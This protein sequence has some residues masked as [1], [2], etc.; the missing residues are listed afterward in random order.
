MY[1]LG[2]RLLVAFIAVIFTA[3]GTVSLFVTRRADTEFAQYEAA[4]Q[5][6]QRTRMAQWLVGYFENG[7]SWTGVQPYAEEM[8]A[9]SGVGVVVVD[10]PGHV[11]AHSRDLAGA[12]SI[13]ANWVGVPLVTGSGAAIGTLYVSPERTIQERFRATLQRSLWLVLLGGSLLAALVALGVSSTVTRMFV[14]P[15]RAISDVASRAGSGDFSRRVAVRGHDEVGE[16]GTTINRMADELETALHQRRNQ[17]AD[18]AHELRSPLTNIRGYLEALQDGVIDVD[19]SVPVIAAEVALLIRLVEDLQELALVES[20]ITTIHPVPAGVHELV[21]RC[22]AAYLPMAAERGALL[23]TDLPEGLPSVMVDAQR[24]A[25]VV[26]NLVRNALQ[27]SP[28]GGTVALT[29]VRTGA[30]V[31]LA[32]SDAGEGMPGEELSRVFERFRRLDPSRSRATGGIGLGLTIARLLVELHG[33]RIH[34]AARPEGGTT[35]A[36]T[37]PVT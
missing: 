9:L 2:T 11:V 21:E 5:H 29:A 25:Q 36:F 19:G 4:S 28:V 8:D 7:D 3:V 23:T 15:I 18:T 37:M 12:G 13:P 30:Y 14:R 27:H 17:I 31:E 6:L 16:L 20:G 26:S 34:A 24:I 32:V 35:V 1:R 22:V 33:G 10:S